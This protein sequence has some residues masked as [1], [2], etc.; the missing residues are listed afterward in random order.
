MTS[1]SRPAFAPSGFGRWNSRQW[2]SDRLASRLTNLKFHDKRLSGL[3]VAVFVTS[4]T[5]GVGMRAGFFSNFFARNVFGMRI[6]A[7]LFAAGILWA[8]GSTPAALAQQP[9]NAAE[10]PAPVALLIGNSIYPD[11]G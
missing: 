6:I 9:A 1:R 10:A 3:W 2:K 4:R 8:A 7:S 5:L 11:A